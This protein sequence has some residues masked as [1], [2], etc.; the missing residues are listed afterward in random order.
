VRVQVG[1]V[2]LYFDVAGMGLS[3]T[4]R[5]CASDRSSCALHGGP[6]LDHTMLKASL[7]PLADVAQLVFLDQRGNGRSEES[8]PDRWNLRARRGYAESTRRRSSR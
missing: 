1:G 5:R 3:R 6:G 2:W 4:G 7:A 8:T